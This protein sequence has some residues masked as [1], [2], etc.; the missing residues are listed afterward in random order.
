M[1][2][3]KLLSSVAALALLSFSANAQTITTVAGGGPNNVPAS[4]VALQ[5]VGGVAVDSSGNF[6][7]AD[8]S[9]NRVFKVSSGT[10]TVVAGNGLAGYGGDG[11]PATLAYLSNPNGVAVDAAGDIFIA[12]TSNC[13]IRE[14]NTSGT[15]STIAGYGVCGYNADAIAAKL[16]YLNN[17]YAVAVDSSGN[18][19]IA[20]TY[21]HRVRMV[22]TSGIIHTVAGIG[23][24][25]YN[26][27]GFPA[28]AAF[29][30]SPYGVAVDLSG[31]VYIAD[32]NN[33]RIREV[34][35]GNIYTVAGTYNCFFN[36]DGLATSADLAN[37][38]GVAVDASG[39]VFL[40]DTNNQRIRE[41][42]GGNIVT[43]AGNGNGGYNGDN[44]TATSVEV[45]NPQG[46][47]VDTSDD[48][49]VADS[50]NH[51]IR[52]LTIGGNMGTAAGN[53]TSAACAALNGYIGTDEVFCSPQ[54]V[55]IDGSGD[56]FI[57]D[58]GAN[59][60]SEINSSGILTV[61]AGDGT[62]GFNGD[63][64]ATAQNLS[65]PTKAIVDSM[66]NVYIADAGSNRIRKVDTS[67]NMTTIAGSGVLGF[68]GD[69]PATSHA[70]SSPTGI[71]FDNS[72]NLLIADYGNDRIRRVDAGGNMTTIVGVGSPGF[73]GDGGLAIYANLNSPRDVAVDST[74]NI[75]I[76][77]STNNR[78]RK[79]DTSGNI[80]TVAGTGSCFLSSDGLA[81]ASA[82]C[83]PSSVSIVGSG[84]IAVSEAGNA[85]VRYIFSDG[86]IKTVAGDGALGFSG[87]GCYGTIASL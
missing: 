43:I 32:T 56:L 35:G 40:S 17:P 63:G 69:G 82:I 8:A 81:I 31:N 18:V 59:L 27:D 84:T 49:F 14:V 21:N 5:T 73:S 4:G 61:L 6:Y 62:F 65:G 53:G 20:D 9:L 45:F 37:P 64:I 54:G 78:V 26:G 57:A 38:K 79:V 3:T 22:D 77:D 48:V 1:P 36:G 2:K 66:G 60:V 55:S 33:C 41:V 24:Y 87:D 85:R 72:G 34:T 47:A 42:I 28:T 16:A 50:Q 23:M 80:T 67:G 83:T 44:F 12:D 74:G 11:G 30:N 7:I 10:L 70:L 39:N 68:D 86:T 76:A 71:A 75:F 58:Q 13:R 25:G 46:V 52:E 29:L 19:Y 51:R 15:I